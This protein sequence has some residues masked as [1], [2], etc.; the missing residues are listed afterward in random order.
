[1]SKMW[2]ICLRT[3]YTILL[4]SAIIVAA[5]AFWVNHGLRNILGQYDHKVVLSPEDCA[6]IAAN[7][8]SSDAARIETWRLFFQHAGEGRTK[9]GQGDLTS[10]E[11]L[12]IYGRQYERERPVHSNYFAKLLSVLD[13]KQKAEGLSLDEVTHYLG[14]PDESVDTTLGRTLRY[15]FTL[16]GQSGFA[17]IKTTNGA[18]LR[19]DIDLLPP[20]PQ[21]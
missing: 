2:R 5:F 20:K 10:R 14:Q 7:L 19:M 3:C 12:E 4:L 21:K 8:S 17:L 9:F 1:M 15:N 11:V 18:V 16:S 13:Q 6:I